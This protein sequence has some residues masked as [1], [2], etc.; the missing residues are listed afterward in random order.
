MP[1][2]CT[3]GATLVEDARFCHKC[4]RPLFETEITP[5]LPVDVPP[6]QQTPSRAALAAAL[7]V[8]FSNPIALHVAFLMSLALMLLQMIPGV[9]LLFAL[10]W[11][12]AGWCAVLL[13]RRI[14]GAV[15]SVRAGARLGTITGV[16]TFLSMAIIFAMTLLF[17]GKDFFAQLAKQD[18]QISQVAGNPPAMA[19]VMLLGLT[20]VFGVVV[21]VC[22]AGGALGARFANRPRTN[23]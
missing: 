8:G 11:L 22:A 1:E 4:G 16:L 13:Y 17:M 19:M 21:G 6:V 20:L 23:G 5:E 2:T 12:G 14:T 15:L 9:N 18:P 7:P 3:C 10:W